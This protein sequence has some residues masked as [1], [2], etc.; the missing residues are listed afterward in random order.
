MAKKNKQT[1][2]DPMVSDNMDAQITEEAVVNTENAVSDDT[3]IS[4][5]GQK[6]EEVLK[7]NRNGKQLG[8][9]SE[10]FSTFGELYD[11]EVRELSI[12]NREN[13]SIAL[14]EAKKIQSSRLSTISVEAS[15]LDGHDNSAAKKLAYRKKP[16]VHTTFKRPDEIESCKEMGMKVVGV[17]TRRNGVD[18]LIELE[19]PE[20]RHM[21]HQMAVCAESQRNKGASKKMFAE[22]VKT[23]A[24][25]AEV[26]V[27][28]EDS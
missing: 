28:K 25:N 2:V 15:F 18:E 20:E 24:P 17:K 7:L 6:P 9:T 21:Q 1:N 26:I 11:Y 3:F 16:G 27:D 5:V 19:Y 10:W 13:Y 22:K 12:R 14:R 8:F 4:L 23:I